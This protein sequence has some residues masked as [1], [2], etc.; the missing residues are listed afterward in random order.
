VAVL[1]TAG[2]ANAPQGIGD[3]GY[4]WTLNPLDLGLWTDNGAVPDIEVGGVPLGY[5]PDLILNS[6][7][8]T[9][10]IEESQ[11][12]SGPAVIQLVLD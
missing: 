6:D 4:L 3:G 2:A 8:A 5:D 7:R 9:A 1:G 10:I 11:T 12:D